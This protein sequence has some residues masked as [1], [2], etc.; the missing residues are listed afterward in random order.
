MDHLA[1]Q[2]LGVANVSVMDP[3]LRW[4]WDARPRQ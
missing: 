3:S 1:R 2:L 4:S